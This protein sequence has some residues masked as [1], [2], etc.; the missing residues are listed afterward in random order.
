MS[1][2]KI[3]GKMFLNIFKFVGGSALMLVVSMSLVSGKFPPPMK[4]YYTNL[5]HMQNGPDL[6]QSMKAIADARNQQK[7]IMAAIEARERGR[8]RP[9]AG[10]RDL[11]DGQ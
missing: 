3:I 1:V 4:E 10:G 2:S 5:R 11:E 7:E 9:G 6:S 8:R